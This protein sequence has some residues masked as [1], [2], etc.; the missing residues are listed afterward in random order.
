MYTYIYTYIYIYTACAAG[1]RTDLR[2][3]RKSGQTIIANGKC[4]QKDVYI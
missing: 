4:L 1:P 2:V 3:G